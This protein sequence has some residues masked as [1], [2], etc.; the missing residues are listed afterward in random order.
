MSKDFTEVRFN[1]NQFIQELND[2]EVLLKSKSSLGEREIQELF[3]ASLNLTAYIGTTIANIGIAQQVAYEFQI[4][5]DFGADIAIGNPE[6]QFCLVELEN[7]DTNSVFEKFGKKSTKEWSRRI[8]HGFSQIVDWFCHL[9]DFKK[10]DRFHRNFGYGHIDFAGLLLIGRSAG[11]DADDRRRLRWRSHNVIVNS[12]SVICMTYDD[13][14]MR[15]KDGY[16]RFSVTFRSEAGQN[17]AV[18]ES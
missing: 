10:T 5:G 3:K 16:E 14:F 4:I 11:L 15:I 17:Q 8:E 12:H 6:R 7:A 1:S 2:F 18:D 9:D 13:L